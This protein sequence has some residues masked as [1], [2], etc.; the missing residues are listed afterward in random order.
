MPEIDLRNLPPQVL[1]R[2]DAASVDL[3]GER[4]EV[5]DRGRV[6][7]ARSFATGE[8]RVDDDGNP[9]I[10]GYATVYEFPYEVAGGPPYGWVET[11]AEG[12]CVKSVRERDDVR[13]LVNHDGVA[14][15]R[16]RSKTLELESD[17]TGLRFASTLDG[18][19]PLVQT[20][21]SA[22]ARGDMDECSFAFQVLRQEWNADFTERRILEVK[23]FDVSVVTYPANPAAVAQL[24]ATEP[25]PEIIP[26]PEG[27]MSVALARALRDQLATAR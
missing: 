23:L 17:T 27:R 21:S 1:E 12:A 7:E 19:S 14:L 25:V 22:M 26:A 24:R 18:R 8:L 5:V 20:L 3:R 10:D 11:I 4:L 9:T 15:G 13:L 2:I 6:L 16:T